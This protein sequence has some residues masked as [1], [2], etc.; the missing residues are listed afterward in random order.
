MAEETKRLRRRTNIST[1]VKGIK[2]FDVIVETE[3][4]TE[5]EHLTE[6]DSLVCQMEKR[7]PAPTEN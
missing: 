3:G 7:C 1:S 5:A 2:T 4:Y 6:L